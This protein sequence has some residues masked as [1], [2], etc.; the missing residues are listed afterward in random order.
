VNRQA[1]N[2]RGKRLKQKR[3]GEKDVGFRKNKS[4]KKCN[5]DKELLLGGRGTHT[6][7]LSLRG[8]VEKRGGRSQKKGAKKKK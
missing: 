4:Q 6:V 8:G 7:K 5:V 2:N 3:G 1:K